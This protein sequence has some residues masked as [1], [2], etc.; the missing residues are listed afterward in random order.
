M[1][2]VIIRPVI[3]EKSMTD[4][5]NGKFTFVV[6]S[7][8]TKKQIKEAVEK[9]FSVHVLKVATSVVKGK[10]TRVG[11]RRVEVVK[12]SI[13]KATVALKSGEKIDAFELGA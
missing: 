2:N 6:A 4:A 9:L 12:T 5:N 1:T 10:T 3:S 8:A 13:K 7:N 11:A